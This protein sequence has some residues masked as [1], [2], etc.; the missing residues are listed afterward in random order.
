MSKRLVSA[1]LVC[2]AACFVTCG[3]SA[4]QTVAQEK[5]QPATGKWEYRIVNFYMGHE[6]EAEKELNKL[7]DEGFEVASTSSGSAGQGGGGTVVVVHMV[8]KRAK[9]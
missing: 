4:K 7:G 5:G 1:A 3:Q 6:K 9:R 2:V 8:L